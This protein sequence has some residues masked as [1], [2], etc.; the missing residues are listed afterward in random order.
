MVRIDGT[1]WNALFEPYAAKISVGSGIR[2]RELDL[3]RLPL[4]QGGEC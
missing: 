2:G 1:E 4:R 3:M